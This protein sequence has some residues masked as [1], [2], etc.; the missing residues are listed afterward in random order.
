M[1]KLKF[2]GSSEELPTAANLEDICIVGDKEY[3]YTTNWEELEVTPS[4]KI[5]IKDQTLIIDI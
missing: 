3:V 4:R 1:N 5:K 2:I